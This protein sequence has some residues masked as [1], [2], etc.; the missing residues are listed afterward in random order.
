MLESWDKEFDVPIPELEPAEE[1]PEEEEIFS[2]AEARVGDQGA[3]VEN[4]ENE[5]QRLV[6]VGVTQT[7]SRAIVAAGYTLDMIVSGE[8]TE[9]HLQG[10]PRIGPKVAAS[11]VASLRKPENNPEP[12]IK[13]ELDKANGERVY[14]H[15]R[16][17]G[18]PYTLLVGMRG[19][20]YWE[21][22]VLDDTWKF[23]VGDGISKVLENDEYVH[24]VD[25]HT[26]QLYSGKVPGAGGF[27]LPR[28]RAE[29]LHPVLEKWGK[30]EQETKPEPDPEPSLKE[31]Y[32]LYIGCR[33]VLGFH[34]KEFSSVMKPYLDRVAT[35]R[36]V[37]DVTL[38]EPGYLLPGLIMERL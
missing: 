33:P 6:S 10:V 16:F 3:A 31:G 35:M 4:S 9:Q 28:L 5:V 12:E 15:H 18:A 24:H 21:L 11:I 30:P 26:E 38:I 36:N 13:P 37:P 34:G 22:Q 2:G 8:C 32:E 1:S 19:D 20:K 27:D 7:R 29:I 25:S 17:Y 14:Y 23:I